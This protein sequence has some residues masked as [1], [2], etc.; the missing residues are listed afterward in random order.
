MRWLVLGILL[1]FSALAQVEDTVIRNPGSRYNPKRM[2]KEGVELG[3]RDLHKP[4]K[5][6]LFNFDFGLSN[7]RSQGFVALAKPDSNFRLQTAQSFHYGLDFFPTRVSLVQH[8]FNLFLHPGLSIQN[9]RLRSDFV[10]RDSFPETPEMAPL[11]ATGVAYRQNKLHTVYATFAVLLN[12]TMDPDRPRRS[13]RASIG[14]YG[15]ALIRTRTRRRS[16][17]FGTETTSNYLRNNGFLETWQYGVTARIGISLI[18]VYLNYGFASVFNRDY[19]NLP[20][21]QAFQFGVRLLAL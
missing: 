10:F 4:V 14:A 12:Y 6:R 3:K 15:G 18:E 17:A 5:I 13:F 8:K 9:Y 16:E 1:P 19:R 7:W 11:G 21:V 2:L 20:E